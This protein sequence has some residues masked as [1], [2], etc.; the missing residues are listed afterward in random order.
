MFCGGT[1][2]QLTLLGN[3]D[4]RVM[5]RNVCSIQNISKVILL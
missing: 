5:L 1:R 2:R 4:K 3:L